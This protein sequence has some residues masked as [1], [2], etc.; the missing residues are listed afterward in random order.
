MNV[1]FGLFPPISE[2][3][4]RMKG[5]ERGRARKMALSHRALRDL[6]LWL[7]DDAASFDSQGVQPTAV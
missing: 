7:N 6:E 2:T 3:G 1:N 5:V 4:K